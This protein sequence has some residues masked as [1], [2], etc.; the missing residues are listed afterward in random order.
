VVNVRR[1]H[2]KLGRGKQRRRAGCKQARFA[3]HR[4]LLVGNPDRERRSAPI[5]VDNHIIHN[6]VVY[7]F[8]INRK[9]RSGWITRR[10][11]PA[12]NKPASGSTAL[13]SHLQNLMRHLQGF[14]GEREEAS[15]HDF[16]RADSSAK[17]CWALAP[18]CTCYQSFTAP[19]R[20]KQDFKAGNSGH[21]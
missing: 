12:G 9:F 7:V 1:R 5:P 10:G 17:R 14:I 19:Q 16:S 8:C 11:P 6:Y 15:R 20:L 21:D 13:M 4:F 2:G 3:N 18:A